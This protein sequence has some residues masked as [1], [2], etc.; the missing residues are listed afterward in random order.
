MTY[1]AAIA[2]KR[3]VSSRVACHPK[4]L[5]NVDDHVSKNMSDTKACVAYHGRMG[6][7][8]NVKKIA[9]K[10]SYELG[11]DKLHFEI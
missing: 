9:W 8:G 4:F 11:R 7:R 6:K 1:T 2:V 10:P 3:V 5:A